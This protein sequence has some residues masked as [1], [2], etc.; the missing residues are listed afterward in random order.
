M[1]KMP[2]EIRLTRD[3]IRCPS[4]TPKE[5]GA[6][7]LLQVELGHMGFECTRLPFGEGAARIDNLFARLGSASPHFAFAGHIDVVPVGN[8]AAW[9]YGPFSGDIKDGCIYGR[10][11]ADMKGGIAAFVA[12]AKRYLEAEKL[13]GSLSL[14]ITG[15]EEAEAVNG[16]VKMVD[17]MTETDNI[18]DFCMV[19]EPTNP[20]VMGQTIKNGRRGSLSCE[21]TVTGRQGHVAYPHLANNPIPALFSM[22]APVNSTKLD[23]GTA[24][25][26]PSTA[27]VTSLKI[28]D[29][30]SNVIPDQVTAQF[31]IRFNTEHTVDSLQGWLDEHFGRLAE[32]LQVS[33]EA[34]FWSNALPFI[35]KASDQLNIV[36]EMVEQVTGQQPDLSTTGG[37]SDARFIAK[38]CPVA[39]FGLVGQTMHQVDEH[40]RLA[41]IETLT[42]IYFQMIRQMDS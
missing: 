11:A 20:S 13:N 9:S 33:Y 41:D 17:W 30:A 8:E 37:T 24:Y 40:V 10:G 6:L 42:E 5:G 32:K 39:E 15:D 38:I 25:F 22:L 21:L 14:I 28:N 2:Y 7:D 4:V 31:N 26:G 12:A 1:A 29:S 18:P 19:G 27:E 35:T 36:R 23:N 34:Q 3:L 16:T